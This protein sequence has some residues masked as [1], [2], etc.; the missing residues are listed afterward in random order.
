MTRGTW[1][2]DGP[3]TCLGKGANATRW[4]VQMSE[5]PYRKPPPGTE[6]FYSR[7]DPE[8]SDEE[9]EI[10]AA[11]FVDSVLDAGHREG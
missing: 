3:A 7:P 1:P 8:M 6:R 10:W 11:Q 9:I 4:G 5:V 2:T